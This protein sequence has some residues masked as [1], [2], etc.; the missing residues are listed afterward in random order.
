M[1]KNFTLVM[2]IFTK[3]RS[4]FRADPKASGCNG[5]LSEAKYV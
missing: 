2:N 5:V 4:S 3:Q 1:I